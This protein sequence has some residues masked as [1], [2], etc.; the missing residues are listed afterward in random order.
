MR[1]SSSTAESEMSLA[2]LSFSVS[3]ERGHFSH[4]FSIL[5][6]RPRGNAEWEKFRHARLD[7]RNKGIDR[8]TRMHAIPDRLPDTDFIFYFSP[9]RAHARQYT[10]RRTINV[11]K[12]REV[13]WEAMVLVYDA[14]RPVFALSGAYIGVK[15][16]PLVSSS[17]RSPFHNASMP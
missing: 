1:A 2:R 7:R 11:S 9:L 17:A 14:Q 15:L 5:F 10:R 16:G 8:I 4:G 13:N 6:W 3:P 12:T